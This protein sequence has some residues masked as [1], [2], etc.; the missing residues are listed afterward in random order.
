[1][2]VRESHNKVPTPHKTCPHLISF[3]VDVKTL[4]STNRAGQAP[5]FAL[6]DV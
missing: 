1:M 4:W 6:D 2:R 5:L 3:K